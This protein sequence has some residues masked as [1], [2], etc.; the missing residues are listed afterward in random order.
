MADEAWSTG[1]VRSLGV[2]LFGDHIDIDEHGE[3]I[4]G[5]TMLLLFN[6][7]HERTIPVTLPELDEQQPWKRL[8][9]TADEDAEAAVFEASQN[10]LLQPASMAVFQ[11]HSAHAAGQE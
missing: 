2:I 6:A 4:S 3:E 5:A 10:Y 8:L 1:Y 9:D 11:L 7:D